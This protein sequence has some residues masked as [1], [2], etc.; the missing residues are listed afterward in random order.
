MKHKCPECGSL[1]GSHTPICAVGYRPRP[2]PEQTAKLPGETVKQHLQRQ[3]RESRA[4][5]AA[6]REALGL[7][8]QNI[9]DEH[10]R[11]V[12]TMGIAGQ[13]VHACSLCDVIEAALAKADA[14]ESGK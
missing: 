14:V 12:G 5:V 3:L 9:A 10:I 13:T 1:Y 6:Y 8:I 11:M 7:E 2:E 4:Q